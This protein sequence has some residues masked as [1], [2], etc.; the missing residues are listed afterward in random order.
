MAREQGIKVVVNN[1]K[2]YHDY[3]IEETFE[4]GLVLVG[5]EVKSLRDGR[6]S[7]RDAYVEVRDNEA[8]MV[9]SSIS[10]YAKGNIWNHDP[11]RDRKL[12][13]HKTEIDRIRGRVHERGYSVVPTKVYFKQ[14]R[15]KVEIALARGKKLYDKRTDIAKRDANRELERELKER[16]RSWE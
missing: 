2:A 3:S 14:G 1:R 11:E 8:W 16:T 5:T 10:H 13:L 4:A 15:A 12:L 6:M 7:V 9:G